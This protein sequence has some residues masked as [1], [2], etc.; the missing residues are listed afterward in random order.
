V[1]ELNI[2]DKNRR[3]TR[4]RIGDDTP[5]GTAVYA[6]IAGD[7]RVFALSSYKKNSFDKSPI[8]LRD[9][10]LLVFDSDK[11]SSIELTAKKQSIAFGRSKDQ[12][13][14]VKPK[15]FRANG[16]QV[17]ELLRTLRDTKMD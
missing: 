5:A 4:L 11:V 2:T 15:P 1:I 8:D 10:R 9:K 12:W 3:T 13:Q 14:I 16:S 6:A 7:P 17:E